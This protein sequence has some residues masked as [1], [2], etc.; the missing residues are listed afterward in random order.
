MAMQQMLFEI[1]RPV[2][3]PALVG[4]PFAR[5]GAGEAGYFLVG[6]EVTGEV[7]SEKLSADLALVFFFEVLLLLLVLVLGLQ[8]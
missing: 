8:R 7:A 4:T 1:V 5:V 3:L 6:A 2:E